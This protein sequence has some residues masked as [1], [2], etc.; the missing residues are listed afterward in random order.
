MQQKKTLSILTILFFMFGFITCLNDI[1]VPYLKGVFTLGYTQAALI[2][3]CFFGAYGL[4]SIPASSFIERHGYQRGIIL[5][6]VLTALGCLMFLPAVEFHSYNIFLFGF[7]VLATGIVFLQVAANPLAA[8]SG[9]AETA[10][11]RLTMTQA[12]NSLGTFLAPFFGSYLILSNMEASSGA[13]GVK[14]PYL[15]IAVL[16]VLMAFLMLRVSFPQAEKSESTGSWATSLRNPTLLGGMLGIFL[17]V[18]AEVTIGTFL[19]N[20]I[21]DSVQMTEAQAAN[22]VAFYWGS[23]MVGRFLGIFT[24]KMYRPGNVLAVHSVLSIV[25]IGIAVKTSGFLS[26]YALILVGLCNSIMFPTIFTLGM[27]DA[28]SPARASG[29]L[30][31]SIIGGAIIPLF[32]GQLADFAGLRVAMLLP[33]VCY[34]Y[35]AFMG[36]KFRGAR[37]KIMTEVA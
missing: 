6:F 17:Y 20:F 7:F 33:G 14:L 31:T 28:D 5:G 32:T 24:L 1:L 13:E 9:P 16:L 21:T 12:F 35:I 8:L 34:L 10:S 19:V 27:K 11:S 25:L 37:M 2:Q 4:T 23:A 15:G 29:L 36:I 22:Y 18:G 30:A 26:V 3:L